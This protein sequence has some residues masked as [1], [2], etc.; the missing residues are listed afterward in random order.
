MSRLFLCALLST[1]LV[2]RGAV[3]SPPAIDVPAWIQVQFA[4]TSPLEFN[5]ET[6]LSGQFTLQIGGARDSEWTLALPEGVQL[7]SGES[8]GTLRLEPGKQ[9]ALSWKI[10]VM[11]P[12]S[13]GTLAVILRTALPV[14]E[15][16]AEIEKRQPQDSPERQSSLRFVDSSNPRPEVVTTLTVSSFPEETWLGE[17]GPVFQR[18][19]ESN[20]GAS[21]ALYDLMPGVTLAELDAKDKELEEQ[22]LVYR[23]A[24]TP[25]KPGDD[26]ARMVTGLEEEQYEVRYHRAVRLL[27]DRK[28]AEAARLL[29]GLAIP[30]GKDTPAARAALLLARAVIPHQQG[31]PELA[32]S[33]IQEALEAAGPDPV[34]RY[35]HYATGEVLRAQGQ[36]GEA[37]K[38]YKRAVLLK[39]SYTRAR[40]R[41]AA[42]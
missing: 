34:A 22:L 26:L 18:Y 32:K 10:L 5:K 42:S 13:G 24:K 31:Q 30:K 7:V 4:P 11:R 27:T 3:A 41:L 20:D 16:K 19:V 1:G 2:P 28:P 39:P 29:E 38:S 23:S 25:A 36:P 33:R 12:V 37:K 8:K 9:A 6:L 35:V 14:A 40:E 21:F 15:L 17:E